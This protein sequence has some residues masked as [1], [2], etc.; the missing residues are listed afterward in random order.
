M[1]TVFV[2]VGMGEGLSMA[3]ARHFAQAGFVIAM[4]ARNETKLQGFQAML[5]AEGIESHYF[6]ADAGDRAGLEVAFAA[7]Q[8]QLGDPSVLVYNAAAPRMQ[9]VLQESFETLVDNFKTNVAGALVAVQAVLPAMQAQ[10]QGTILLTGGGFALNPHPDFASLAIGKAG[11]R[12]LAKS[13]ALALK[14]TKIRVGTI[15]ICG[16]VNPDDPKY[17]PDLIAEQFWAFHTIEE[18]DFE[19]VY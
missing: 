9:N 17:S 14:E 5:Q 1:T 6:V 18:S 10:N 11:I 15:T 8:K 12:S 4:I 3:I 16:I 2:I 13:L 19:V 7:I